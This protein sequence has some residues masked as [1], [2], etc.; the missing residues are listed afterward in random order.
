MAAA[1]RNSPTDFAEALAL[2]ALE[3]LSRRG[4]LLNVFLGS[5][6]MSADDL[7][8]RLSDPEVLAAAMDFLMLD[9]RWVVDFAT[10]AGIN[11]EKILAVRRQLPGGD[12]P[13]WT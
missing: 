7:R 11:P 3:F 6:G 4:D 2:K 10:E 8:A 13:H 1:G 9:D 12:L 5:T